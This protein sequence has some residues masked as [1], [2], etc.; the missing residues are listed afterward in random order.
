MIYNATLV[1]LD[2]PPPGL[3]GP[4]LE[5]PCALAQL[6]ELQ[7]RMSDAGTWGATSVAYLPAHDVPSPGP[8]TG[9][10][11]RVRAEGDADAVSYP[12]VQVIQ[13]LGHTLAHTQVYLGPAA[14]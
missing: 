10:H 6:S 12:I 3:P 11:A 7:Q 4:D 8:I 14:G 2:P 13:R 9:G 5:V 1:R